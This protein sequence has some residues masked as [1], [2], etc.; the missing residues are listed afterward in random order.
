MRSVSLEVG[1]RLDVGIDGVERH[2]AVRHGP[3][4]FDLVGR[5][6]GP[7]PQRQQRRQRG[8]A[9]VGRAREDGVENRAGP[10]QRGRGG[11]DLPEAELVRFLLQDAA[12]DHDVDREIEQSALLREGH[13]QRRLRAND[14]RGRDEADAARHRREG[15]PP[16]YSLDRLHPWHRLVSRSVRF[17]VEHRPGLDPVHDRPSRARQQTIGIGPPRRCAAPSRCAAGAGRRALPQ[18]PRRVLPSRATE[19]QA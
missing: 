1:D 19:V 16:A 6:A 13:L 14:G 8:G 10:A 15:L 2:G 3:D 18:R 5:A 17:L 4:R 7:F 9:V 12:A 11:F